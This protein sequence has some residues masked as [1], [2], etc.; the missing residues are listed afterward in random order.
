MSQ[1]TILVTGGAGFVGS[2]MAHRLTEEGYDVVVVDNLSTGRR[3]NVPDDA[4][5]LEADLSDPSTYESLRDHAVDIVFHL[6]GQSSGE[7]SFDDPMYDLQ[8]HVLSTFHLLQFCIEQD[9]ERV[10]YAS[11]MSVYGDPEYQPVDERH[12][13]DPKTFYAAG[14]LGAEA[15]IK[16]FDNLGL[17]TTIFR[18]F[19]I[20]G[21]GQNMENMKQGMVS[22][23]LSFVLDGEELL[24]KGSTDRFRDFVYID[25]VVDAWLAAIDN[26][27]TFGE[28]FN[29]ARGERVEVAELVETILDCYGADDYPIEV[30]DG[31]PGDQFG[32]YGDATKLEEAIDWSATT[33][34]ETGLEKMI[35]A[36]A[37]S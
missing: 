10:L 25:D 15:Y 32:I 13:V 36:E 22:I 20:Y 7:K 19:S 1:E 27:A 18:L 5:F 8:S 4:T 2:A 34:L 3:S 9:V 23:Y 24:I 17:D 21:P 11:S 6:A 26:P 28:T 12:P 33:P 14:K 30:T 29:L 16:L 35:D 31:T 37:N